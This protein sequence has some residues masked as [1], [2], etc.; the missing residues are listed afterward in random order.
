MR[1]EHLLERPATVR[2]RLLRHEEGQSGR[3]RNSHARIPGEGECYQRQVYVG[4]HE[5]KPLLAN[6]APV[7]ITR[8]ER[9]QLLL[10]EQDEPMVGNDMHLWVT[11]TMQSPD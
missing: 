7:L 8:H 4:W 6:V 10:V 2:K 1:N 9:R 3:Q 11:P 5:G